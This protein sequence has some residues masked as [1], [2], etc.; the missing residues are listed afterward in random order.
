MMGGLVSRYAALR[1]ILTAWWLGPVGSSCGLERMQQKD[2]GRVRAVALRWLLI[3]NGALAR[4]S[5]IRHVRHEI[6]LDARYRP[7]NP[8]HGPSQGDGTLLAILCA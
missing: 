7:P 6:P 8:L 1:T 5:D 4:L 2:F 3:K